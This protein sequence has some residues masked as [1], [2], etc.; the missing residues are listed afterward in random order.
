MHLHPDY[1]DTYR[2]APAA[3]PV[4][5]ANYRRL[6]SLPLHPR[7]S[8]EDVADVITAVLDIARIFRR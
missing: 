4:A 1:R 7:L 3:F 5:Y 8:D 2:W 6:I